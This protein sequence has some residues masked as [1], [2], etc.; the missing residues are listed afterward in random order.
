MVRTTE[1]R[2]YKT[3]LK[4]V[5]MYGCEIWPTTKN[6]K[7]VLNTRRRTIPEWYGTV[8]EQGLWT[9]RINQELRELYNTS[10]LLPDSKRRLEWLRHII[11][12]DQGWVRNFFKACKKLKEKQAGP[13]CDGWKTQRMISKSSN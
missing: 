2:I 8:T 3:M 11:R 1:T 9:I 10:D 13:N 4:Q 12:M 5:M 6:S 7:T